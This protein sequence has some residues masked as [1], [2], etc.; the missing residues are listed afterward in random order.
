[1]LKKFIKWLAKSSTNPQE[2]SLTVK[3]ALIGIIPILIGYAQLA[4]LDWS[5]EQLMQ[6]IEIITSIVSTFFVLIGL[7]RKLYLTGKKVL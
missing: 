1:M 4:G 6:T 2:V 5:Q 3:G 7:I